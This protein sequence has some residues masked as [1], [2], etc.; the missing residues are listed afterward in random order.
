MTR[1]SGMLAILAILG[2]VCFSCSDSGKSGP[3]CL[4]PDPLPADVALPDGGELLMWQTASGSLAGAETDVFNMLLDC[5]PDTGFNVTV[6]LTDHGQADIELSYD[7]AGTHLT[8]DTFGPGIGEG[9][10]LKLGSVVVPTDLDIGV[11]SKNQ[12][13]AAYTI[14]VVPDPLPD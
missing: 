8:V 4:K 3:A 1:F 5:Q 13:P 6:E 9:S 2:S 11:S 7:I 14:N 10:I 12:Q